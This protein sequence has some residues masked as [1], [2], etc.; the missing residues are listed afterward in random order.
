M[1]SRLSSTTQLILT[2]LLVM[3]VHLLVFL[4]ALLDYQAFDVQEPEAV[5][6]KTT[7]ASSANPCDGFAESNQIR[8]VI[9]NNVNLRLGPGTRHERVTFADSESGGAERVA[10]LESGMRVL[11]QCVSGDWARI[12][13]ERPRRL[14]ATHQGWVAREFLR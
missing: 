11:E 4:W 13:V 5:E 1:F 8:A 9:G 7:I 10:R 2:T 12:R 14:N 6:E 3:G